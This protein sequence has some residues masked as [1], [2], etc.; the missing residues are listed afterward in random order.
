M[1]R[2][3]DGEHWLLIDQQE[4]AHLAAEVAAVWCA[5]ASTTNGVPQWVRDQI[6]LAVARHD[7]G[8]AVWDQAPR[9]DPA[10]GVPRDFMEMRMADSTEIWSRSIE[11]CAT[12]P[13]SAY[14]VSRHFCYLAE[15]VRDGRRSD[16]DDLQAVDRFLQEQVA[17]Q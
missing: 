5:D 8:W 7:D 17:V 4:H 13:L 6:W 11:G 10:T 2:R 14:A 12:H 16:L 9:V 15:Q 1:I 3:D